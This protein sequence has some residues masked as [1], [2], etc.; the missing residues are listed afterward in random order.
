MG[1]EEEWKR[2]GGGQA[3][4]RGRKSEGRRAS[5]G[6]EWLTEWMKGWMN[7]RPQKVTGWVRQTERGSVSASLFVSTLVYVSS[8]RVRLSER[9]S[10]WVSEW[11]S[12]WTSAAGQRKTERKKD[13]E[14]ERGYVP[15]RED[16]LQWLW[17]KYGP[18]NTRSIELQLHSSLHSSVPP[19]CHISPSR[20]THTHTHVDILIHAH[21]GHHTALTLLIFYY[22]AALDL[23][24]L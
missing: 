17:L 23:R 3:R 9:A 21:C 24:K 7:P 8:E 2:A 13:R 4:R 18:I 12:G 19:H 14:R 15:S 1:E 5:E 22:S 10:E 20:H 16:T 6:A 11:M